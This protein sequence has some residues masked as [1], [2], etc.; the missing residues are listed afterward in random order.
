MFCTCL[1][2]Q[3][4]HSSSWHKIN[5][6]F[7]KHIHTYLHC[8]E[9]IKCNILTFNRAPSCKG[10]MA[11]NEAG[12]RGCKRIFTAVRVCSSMAGNALSKPSAKNYNKP[13]THSYCRKTVA[14]FFRRFTS[15]WNVSLIH[16]MFVCCLTRIIYKYW[17]I[18][19][20]FILNQSFFFSNN[21]FHKSPR[22]LSSRPKTGRNYFPVTKEVRVRMGRICGE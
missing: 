11:E 18:T 3:L 9:C 10:C 1:V 19:Q 6:S 21:I 20:N 4:G 22:N 15:N 2:C 16:L 13:T 8:V 5:L 17:N 7:I 12:F 14:V